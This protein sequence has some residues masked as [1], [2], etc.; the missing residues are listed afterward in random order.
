MGPGTGEPKLAEVDFVIN[1]Q[2]QC[3]ENPVELLATSN[4]AD[5]LMV[6]LLAMYAGTQPNANTSRD[7]SVDVTVKHVI[8]EQTEYF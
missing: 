8:Q 7:P 2:Q 1:W 6:I 5:Q 4:D 3:V